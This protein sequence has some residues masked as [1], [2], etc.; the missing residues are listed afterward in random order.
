MSSSSLKDD[1]DFENSKSIGKM[2]KWQRFWSS[3]ASLSS[4][5]K[6]IFNPHLMCRDSLNEVLE[7]TKH[8]R[9]LMR[10]C[11][12]ED[13]EEKKS[14]PNSKKT[15]LRSRM[16][17]FAL[18]E[19]STQKASTETFKKSSQAWTSIAVGRHADAIRPILEHFLYFGLLSRPLATSAGY[20]KVDVERRLVERATEATARKL[21]ERRRLLD[22]ES[23]LDDDDDDC[24][25]VKRS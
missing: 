4:S 9:A 5:S 22:L 14:T 2:G 15:K 19:L 12:H 17:L 23:I 25:K 24:G 3:S 6:V 21:F 18:L 20:V 1:E 8:L 7:K 10:L 13:K 11:L 16:L